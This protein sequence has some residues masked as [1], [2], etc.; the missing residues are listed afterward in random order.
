MYTENDSSRL[1]HDIYDESKLE[2]EEYRLQFR[3]DFDRLIHAPS[4]RRLQGKTQLYP[5]R[6]SDFFRNRLTH[7]LEVAQIAKSIAIRINNRYFD[8]S[9]AGL[10]NHID[11]DVVEFAGVAHDLGHPPFGHQGEEALDEMMVDDGGFEG[12]AQTLRLLSRIEKKH[13]GT[14]DEDGRDLRTGLNLTSRVLAS[15]SKYDNVIPVNKG[16]RAEYANGKTIKPVKGYYFSEN[17]IV[18]SVKHLVLGGKETELPFKT[19]ECKIMDISDDIA[20]S[21]YDLEDGLKAGF[22]NPFDIVFAKN[23]LMDRIAGRVSE[24]LKIKIAIDDVRDV[25]LSVFSECFKLPNIEDADINRDTFFNHHILHMGAAYTTAATLSKDGF[26]RTDFTSKLVGKF[27][28]GVEFEF[29]EEFPMLS[30]VKLVDDILLE[31]E[32]LKTFNYESQILSPRLKIAEY[33]GKEIVRKIFNVLSD[34]NN[35]GYLLMPQDYVD[36]YNAAGIKTKKRIIC[37]FIAGMTDNYCI[38][39]YGRLTSENPETIFKPY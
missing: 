26:A 9:Q 33:R 30:D 21:T 18:R 14:F 16:L 34:D 29:N 31:V 36:L 7:S 22:F 17:E 32:V 8:K 39:F 35:N 24:K 5:G 25:L 19:I 2:V 3:R 37:D 20:Y 6:E 23:E 10:D 28:R 38:E 1:F 12:N 27:I 4:F 15:I 13:G 11:L